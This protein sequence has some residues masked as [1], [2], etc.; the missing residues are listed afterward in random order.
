VITPASGAAMMR[1]NLQAVSMLEEFEQAQF[2]RPCARLFES[3]EQGGRL[4]SPPRQPTLS[5]T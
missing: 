4:A 3:G 5:T 1:K 2:E